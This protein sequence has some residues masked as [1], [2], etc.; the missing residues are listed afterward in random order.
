MVDC[1]IQLVMLNVSTDANVNAF[2]FVALENEERTDVVWWMFL[3]GKGHVL[4]CRTNAK[5]SA[6][7]AAKSEA[8]ASKT[9]M[10]V[11]IRETKNLVAVF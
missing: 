3:I 9:R 2:R 4:T 1:V 5:A 11:Q 7:N 8:S 6:A 10:Q